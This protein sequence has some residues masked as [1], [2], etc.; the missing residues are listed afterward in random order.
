MKNALSPRTYAEIEKLAERIAQRAGYAGVPQDDGLYGGEKS[1][2]LFS[3]FKRKKLSVAEQFSAEMT[4]FL[5]NWLEDLM[6][7][8]YNEKQAL[9]ATQEQFSDSALT[10]NLNE[11]FIEHG[12]LEMKRN[13]KFG[14]TIGKGEVVMMF[15]AAFAIIGLGV[16]FLAGKLA[17]MQAVGIISGLIIGAG[18][19]IV[20]HGIILLE[21]LGKDK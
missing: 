21:N 6:R 15:Y 9:A 1:G 2:G 19:G 12:G 16:G 14:K 17:D 7:N 10:E 18:M 3:L 20:S 8:G 13:D 4:V 5:L 11:F